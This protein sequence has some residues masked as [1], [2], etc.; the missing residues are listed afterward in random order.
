MLYKD[1]GTTYVYL[2]Y[3]L[4]YLFN[5]VTGKKEQPQ[6]VLLRGVV[7]YNGPA[8]LTKALEINKSLFRS[9]T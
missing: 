3:G 1:G 8:K 2:C 9:I 6:A 5:I 7:G 4:H